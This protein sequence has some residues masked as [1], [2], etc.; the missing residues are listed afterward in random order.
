MS[1]DLC[2]ISPNDISREGLSHILNSAGFNI[3][4]TMQNVGELPGKALDDDFIAL[5]DCPHAGEQY[6]A[7]DQVKLRHPSAKPVVLSEQF[8]VNAM[9]QCFDHGAHGYI[10][11]TMRS[12]PLTTA[13]RLVALGEKV[14]PSEFVGALHSHRFNTMDQVEADEDFDAANLSQRERDVLCCLMAG[15]SNKVIARQ[16][17]VCEATVKVHV[18]GIL[19]KLKVRNR[20]QAAIWASARGMSD[21]RPRL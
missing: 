20:T 1:N 5:I 12:E 13:F 16:L 4:A 2:L 19:R 7:I 3:V 21:S 11:K 14:V 9:I 10:V 15:Y 6:D 18:K 17:E 8:D